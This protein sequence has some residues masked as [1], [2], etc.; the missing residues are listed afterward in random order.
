[1]S[2]EKLGEVGEAG[3]DDWRTSGGKISLQTEF[4]EI[5]LSVLSNAG[6]SRKAGVRGKPPLLAERLLL[7]VE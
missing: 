6:M 7:E 1:M 5:S 3:E 2:K 4:P